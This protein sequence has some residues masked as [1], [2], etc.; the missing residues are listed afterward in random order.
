MGPRQLRKHGM[1]TSTIL[2]VV[3]LLASSASVVWGD[4]NNAMINWGEVTNGCRYSVRTDQKEYHYSQPVHL[5]MTLENIGDG[6]VY[7][8]LANVSQMYRVDLRLPNGELSP[9]TLEGL[10]QSQSFA[11]GIQILDPGKTAYDSIPSLNR[12]YDMTL[13]GEYSLT[14]YRRLI[15]PGHKDDWAEVPSNHTKIIIH[16]E[17]DA[18]GACPAKGEY[19]KEKTPSPENTRKDWEKLDERGRI[20]E[21]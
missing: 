3:I 7:V 14:V 11:T 5:L 19:I 6:P 12:L 1:K 18:A 10:R 9:P 16:N 20:I 15:L 13:A 2:T 4:T 8:L 21:M 17:D